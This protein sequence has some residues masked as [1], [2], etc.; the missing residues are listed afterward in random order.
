[1]SIRKYQP[2][3]AAGS[4]LIKPTQTYGHHHYPRLGCKR[5]PKIFF[6]HSNLLAPNSERRTSQPARRCSRENAVFFFIVAMDS[7]SIFMEIVDF[8]I[9]EKKKQ[10]IAT[11]KYLKI[12]QGKW[13]K[14]SK[15]PTVKIVVRLWRKMW[16]QF[17]L[18]IWPRSAFRYGLFENWFDYTDFVYTSYAFSISCNFCF[19]CCSPSKINSSLSATK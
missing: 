19:A 4:R 6:L 9:Y 16:I 15:F 3:A 18:T 8:C 11:H 5:T 12:Y 17:H 2:A 13:C 1:M 7:G 10:I 14:M